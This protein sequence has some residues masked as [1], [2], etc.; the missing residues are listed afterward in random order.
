MILSFADWEV[1]Y[2]F[3]TKKSPRAVVLN[4]ECFHPDLTHILFPR[5]RLQIFAIPCIIHQDVIAHISY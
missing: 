4:S 5:V 1:D 3:L 2:K